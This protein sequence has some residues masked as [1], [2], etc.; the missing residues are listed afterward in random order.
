M[1]G[2]NNVNYVWDTRQLICSH[3]NAV[4]RMPKPVSCGVWS[5][6]GVSTSPI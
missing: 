5:L 3:Q 4:K 2:Y 1:H 6:P